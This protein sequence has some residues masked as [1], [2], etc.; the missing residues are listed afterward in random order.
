MKRSTVYSLKHSISS[1]MMILAL[2]WLTISLPF[3]YA[4]QQQL[5]LQT[6]VNSSKDD[7]GSSKNDNSNPFS[8]TTE[9]KAPGNSTISEEYLHG[10]NEHIELAEPRLNHVHYH[11]YNVYVAFHGE[12]ISPPPE[13]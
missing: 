7:A 4:A 12:L 1:V 5:A 8:N 3:V 10:H 11:F 2:L 13:A 6:A 9:E